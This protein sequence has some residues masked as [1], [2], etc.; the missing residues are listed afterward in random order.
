MVEI[1]ARENQAAERQF[2]QLTPVLQEM[3]SSGDGFIE[4]GEMSGNVRLPQ[5]VTVERMKQFLRE[6]AAGIGTV[7]SGGVPLDAF[8][9]EKNTP[10]VGALL[11]AIRSNGGN[12]S[13]SLKLGTSDLSIVGPAWK[14]PIAVYG[15][16]DSTLDHTPI[17]CI[18]LEEYGKAVA[19]LAG[20][21]KRLTAASR[22]AV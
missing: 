6:A 3:H 13:F 4:E 15:P 5:R 7:E 8:R 11:S 21:L 20:V 16:G 18:F 14:C 17:E 10:V 2:D 9:A 1:C 22:S 19:V 12:P